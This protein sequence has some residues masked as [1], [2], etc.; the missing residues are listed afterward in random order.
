MTLK[1]T[2]FQ[3][4]KGKSFYQCQKK[5]LPKQTKQNSNVPKINFWEYFEN[6]NIIS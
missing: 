3:N 5:L 2:I 1:I 6:Y 4:L